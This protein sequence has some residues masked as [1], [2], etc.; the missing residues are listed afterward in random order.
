MR[1]AIMHMNVRNGLNAVRNV[2]TS[3]ARFFAVSSYPANCSSVNFCVL[4]NIV[5]GN[6]Y[7]N[8]INCQPFGFPSGKALIIKKSHNH[9]PDGTDELHIYPIDSELKSIVEKY[10][11]TCNGIV[12]Y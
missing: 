5:D 10:D 6:F 1:D 4:G 2:I 3:N 8:N 12:E 7:Q 11:K 9:F